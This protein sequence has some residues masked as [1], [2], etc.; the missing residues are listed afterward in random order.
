[1]ILAPNFLSNPEEL[2]PR[3]LIAPL[4]RKGRTI[5]TTGV[6]GFLLL[7]LLARFKRF[8]RTTYRF[9]GQ[10]TFIDDW[11]S[12]IEVTAADDYGL[13]LS[14]ARCIE[15]VKGYG[16]T[17]E[18]GLTRYRATMDSIDKVSAGDRAQVVQQLH[19]A[20][21]ADE[22]GQAFDYTLARLEAAG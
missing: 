12:R 16:D 19:S 13:A 17:Y 1:M 21:L 7:S 6:S 10:Q 22:N 3:K 4:F 2:S 20:A 15:I 18:R 9:R 5:N 11:L 8:R 14:I